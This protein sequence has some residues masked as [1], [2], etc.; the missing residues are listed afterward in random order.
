M[1]PIVGFAI[2]GPWLINVVTASPALLLV[3]R[4]S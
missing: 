2:M 1:A 4:F 3:A